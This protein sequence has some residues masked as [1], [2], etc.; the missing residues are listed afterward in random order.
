MALPFKSK[1]S[2]RLP[3]VSTAQASYQ[4]GPNLV[5]LLLLIQFLL[6]VTILIFS[7]VT[8]PSTDPHGLT[9]GIAVMIAVSAMACQFALF[10]LAIPGAIST[11]VM[12]GNLTN[13]VLSL[14]DLL[15]RR[16]PLLPDDARRLKR[17]L[18]LLA[19]FLVGCI[20]AAWA[21]SVLGD[22]A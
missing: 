21:V 9:T 12:T 18:Q 10:R 14:I 22:W 13:A 19:G 1:R 16:A 2:E 4:R 7:V 5:R 20:M 17:A 8:T 3:S 15:S 6:L 11:A